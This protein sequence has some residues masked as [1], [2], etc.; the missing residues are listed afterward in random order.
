MDGAGRN[1]DFQIELLLGPLISLAPRCRLA[2]PAFDL[3]AAI[4]RNDAR[5]DLPLV[6]GSDP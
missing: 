6:C 4:Q 5:R 3:R 2:N 1:A